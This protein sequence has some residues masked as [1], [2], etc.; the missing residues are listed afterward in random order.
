MDGT[1]FEASVTN[2][3]AVFVVILSDFTNPKTALL[4]VSQTP[5]MGPFPWWASLY[6]R[7]SCSDLSSVSLM[8]AHIWDEHPSLHKMDFFNQSF[9]LFF[10]LLTMVLV[11][12][13][14]A[15]Q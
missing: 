15:I 6:F 14:A 2:S 5:S 1:A 7:S 4:I 3:S 13:I 12:V 8:Q 11:Q 9:I 10:N